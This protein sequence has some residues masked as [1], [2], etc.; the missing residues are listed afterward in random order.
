MYLT[1]LRNQAFP[2][3]VD[4]GNGSNPADGEVEVKGRTTQSAEVFAL[5]FGGMLITPWRT[6][7]NGSNPTQVAI[8]TTAATT[9]ALAPARNVSA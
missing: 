9:Q 7:I 1:T 3:C 5:P 8:E 4:A 6:I 2:D